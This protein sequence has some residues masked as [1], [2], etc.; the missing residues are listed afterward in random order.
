MAVPSPYACMFHPVIWA[1]PRGYDADWSG[2][3]AAEPPI[4]RKPIENYLKP[5]HEGDR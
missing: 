5:Y 1:N 3:S 4:G 2:N